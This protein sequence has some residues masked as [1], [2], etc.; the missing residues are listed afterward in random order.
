MLLS[1][2][3]KLCLKHC[4]RHDEK[5]Q[6]MLQMSKRSPVMSCPGTSV[7]LTKRTFYSSIVKCITHVKC[8]WPECYLLA[9]C[10]HGIDG[11]D[12]ANSSTSVRL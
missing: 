4:S 9:K 2:M 3:K 11:I 6:F 5:I 1:K 10:L 7:I 8:K 12:E